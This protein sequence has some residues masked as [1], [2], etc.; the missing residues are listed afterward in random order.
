MIFNG[1]GIVS[2]INGRKINTELTN[3]SLTIISNNFF[4]KFKVPGKLIKILKNTKSA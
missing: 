4:M 3:H 1:I 2:L